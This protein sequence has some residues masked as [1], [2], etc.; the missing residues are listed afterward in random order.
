MTPL[1]KSLKISIYHVGFLI[2]FQTYQI[3][4]PQLVLPQMIINA[5]YSDGMVLNMVGLTDFVQ[6]CKYKPHC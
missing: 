6:A 5:D 4:L 1:Q 3:M 2:L